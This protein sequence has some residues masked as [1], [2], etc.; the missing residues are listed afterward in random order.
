MVTREA[1][2]RRQPWNAILRGAAALGFRGTS[3]AI[4]DLL[5][6]ARKHTGLDDFGDPAFLEPLTLLTREFE[7]NA[8]ADPTGG[9]VFAAMLQQAL[10]NRLYIRKA[11]RDHPDIARQDIVGPVFIVGMPRTGTT[12][13]QGLLAASGGLRT[14][15]MWE[16]KPMPAPP[17]LA[18]K[19]AIARHQRAV[20]AEVRATKFLS[21]RLSAA[22]EFGAMMPE[23]CNPLLMTSMR[24][25]FPSAMMECPEYE[26]YLFSCGFGD[27]Y[28]WHRAH[29][30]FLSY[31]E[32]P[33]TW[34]LKAPAHMSSLAE[35]LRTY[36]DARVIFTHR[37]PKESVA[38]MAALAVCLHVLL[39]PRVDR[40]RVGEGVIAAL[41]KSQA[42]GHAVRDAW[43]LDAPPFID[44]RYGDLTKEPVATV[45][46]ILRHFGMPERE[47][48]DTALNAYLAE[49]G[50]HRRGVHRY[51]LADFDI[52]EAAVREIFDR[53]LALAV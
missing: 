4:D 52:S 19:R 6:R 42:R 27:A 3:V 24:A 53:E 15:L 17:A 9:Q 16:T 5:A 41:A 38:S 51:E 37:H 43:P 25:R 45:R 13:L 18:G 46:N 30:R 7:R 49:H 14:P 34:V 1:Y 50:Q 26:E 22:H 11:L 21:P 31:G 23:E 48:L 32:A 20:N 33:V 39:S 36:P 35:L 44:V 2:F 10:C 29:L 12:L 28:D 40:R 8:G 47:G